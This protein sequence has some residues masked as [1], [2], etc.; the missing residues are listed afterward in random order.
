MDLDVT[1]IS[2]LTSDASLTRIHAESDLSTAHISR[3]TKKGFLVDGPLL[4]EYIPTPP[5]KRPRDSWVYDHDEGITRKRDGEELWLCCLCYSK[6]PPQVVTEKANVTNPAIRHL[7]KHH[8]FLSD[9]QK[10]VEDKKRK[11]D[12]QQDLPT[13]VQR[14]LNAQTAIFDQDDWQS[15]FLAWAVSD[16]I[17]LRKAVSKRHR[18]L[19]IYRNP[20]LKD[21]IPQ[22]KTTMRKLVISAHK[23][24]KPVV[25][26]SLATAKS[27]ITLS[28]DAWK[29]D[30]DLD[31]LAIIAHYIDEQYNVKNVLLAL[32]NTYGSHAAAEMKH[33]LLAVV[34][35]YRITTKLAFFIADS[36]N[37]NDAALDLLQP[38]LPIQPSKQRLRCGCHIINL[39]AKAILYGC[40]IDCIEDALNDDAGDLSTIAGVSHF[41]AI[42]HGKD[43]LAKLQAWRKKGPIGKLHIVIRHA[44][45]SPAR[46]QFFKN[47]QRE[48]IPDAE[49]IYSLVLDRGI[50][51]N[52]TYDMLE[53]AFKLKDAI[54]LYQGHYKGGE[55]E[56][57]EDDVLTNDDWLELRELLDLLLPLRAVSLTLQSDGKDCN[58]GSL[59]QSLPAIDY[60][61]TKL[62]TLK[63]KHTY[64]P[65]THFKAAINLGWKKLDKY[66]NLSDSTPAYRA[67]I[68]VHPAKKMAWFE[69]K[70]KEQHPQWI[71]DARDAVHSLYLEYLSRHADEA[72]LSNQP[73]KELS[74]FELY[75]RIEDEHSLTDDFERY[76]REE[77]A[78]E[79]TNPLTWWRANQHR[80]PILRHMA[81]DLL[82]A[83]ASSAADE[84]T[85]SKAGQVLNEGRYNT[86]ADLAE[87]NQCCKSWCSE[88]LIWQHQ[89]GTVPSYFGDGG[90]V[91]SLT[92]ELR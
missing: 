45:A 55:D 23:A 32:R 33:H 89:D 10:A 28:F 54:E 74:E 92:N 30:N 7:T 69:N 71:D 66:Y 59:W 20:I 35:E 8:G 68:V 91:Y 3:R 27:R 62:E 80:Y 81:L 53:R 70:W 84:R 22:S 1:E 43:E 48:A 58:H 64:L 85:F 47:K 86:L 34:R 44:R 17:S 37:N 73:A 90:K 72:L 57:L 56:P 15:Y 39:V 13:T 83:P 67:A 16:D 40:D 29:S 38:D 78:P 51:W 21:V 5:R 63:V 65:N 26:H 4:S 6:K 9:G 76:L 49:R 87:A 46:R 77:R 61:I 24:L 60:L 52:S 31:M 11:R 82:A 79:G 19:L 88:G 2:S 12:D 14:Q 25:I 36:A 42:L 18:K 50:K 41:E 75:N